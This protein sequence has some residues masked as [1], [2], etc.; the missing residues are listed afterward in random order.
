MEPLY[1]A[2]SQSYGIPLPQESG[3]EWQDTLVTRWD[4]IAQVG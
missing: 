2:L 1:A 4:E 3:Y